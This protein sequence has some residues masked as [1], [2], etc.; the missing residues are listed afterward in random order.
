MVF[1]SE[2]PGPVTVSFIVYFPGLEKVCDGLCSVLLEPSP[3]SQDYFEMVP[4]DL[5]VKLTVRGTVPL[6][7]DPEKLASGALISLISGNEV[8]YSLFKV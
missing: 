6:S 4:L 2:P 1:V 5:S 8:L 3:K 7:G